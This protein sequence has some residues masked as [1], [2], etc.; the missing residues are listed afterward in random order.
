MTSQRLSV[1]SVVLSAAIWLQSPVGV[2]RS[3]ILGVMGSVRALGI[4]PLESPPTTSQYLSIQ[5]FAQSA[6]VRPEYNVKLRPEF[7][8]QFWGGA[9]GPKMVQIEMSSPHFYATSI[10]T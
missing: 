8:P 9:R 10:H 4:L 2:L 6:A 5:S 7:D 3:P 1:Q